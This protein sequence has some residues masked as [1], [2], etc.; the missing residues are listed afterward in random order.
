MKLGVDGITY[1]KDPLSTPMAVKKNKKSIHCNI[2]LIYII[3]I[4]LNPINKNNIKNH[5]NK[6]IKHKNYLNSL[7]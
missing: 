3:T 6:F 2:I 1:G 5:I 4:S 7:K